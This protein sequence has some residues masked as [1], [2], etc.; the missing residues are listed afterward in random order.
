MKRVVI[1][2]IG[3]ITPVGNDIDTLWSSLITGK[4]GIGPITRFDV[5]E[6]KVKIAAEVKDFDA[7][8]YIEKSQIKK[9]DL[10]C[11]YAIA[12]ATQAM[13][14]SGIENHVEPERL[15]VYFGSGIGGIMTFS[16]ET[17]KL[18]TKGPRKVSPH[19]IPKLIANIGAGTIAIKYNAKGPCIPIVT[20]CATSTNTLGEAFRAIKHG[21]ADA[22]IAGGA[23]AAIT[24][25]GLAGFSNMLALA[26]TEDVTTASIPFDKR[27]SG[28][29]MGEGAGALILEEY[30]HAK[31]RGAK[32]YGEICGYGCTCDAHHIT[33]PDPDAAGATRAIAD[34]IKEA[35]F[36]N[37]DNIYINAHGT[38][39]PLNDVSE[40]RAIKQALNENA[41]TAIVSSTKSMTGH[42]LGAAGAVE[43]IV[44]LL[45]LREG[46]IPPTIGLYE[47]D[48]E[49]DLDYVPNQARKADV[50]YALS[51]SLG[52]G[53]HNACI[54]FKR[55]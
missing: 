12:A 22:I 32:I 51:T 47:P 50:K 2:G 4:C 18:L 16:T 3:A 41:K 38:S 45:A 35:N 31:N 27:R 30:E 49:C 21:Y 26:T 40:T 15:G 42:M 11:Q 34:A 46:I 54:A 28:F 23:E 36:D 39:T 7:T 20:A 24:P 43:A 52:F 6:H 53:G 55:V 44:S 37:L 1:T 10:Y 48:P 5:T 25:V 17:E 14:D 8:Q 9:N 19:F 33:A 13:N 29:V